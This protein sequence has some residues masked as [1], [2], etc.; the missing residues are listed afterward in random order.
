MIEKQF[1]AHNNRNHEQSNSCSR[2]KESFL[3]PL[4][5]VAQVSFVNVSMADR[6]L[7]VEDPSFQNK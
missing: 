5:K 2:V 4:I 7:G 3:L 6:S 1:T